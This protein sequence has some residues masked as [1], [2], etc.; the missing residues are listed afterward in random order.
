[1]GG[2]D[3]VAELREIRNASLYRKELFD[4]IIIYIQADLFVKVCH[5]SFSYTEINNMLHYASEKN[6]YPI[7]KETSHIH[8]FINTTY[9]RPFIVYLFSLIFRYVY[10]PFVKPLNIHSIYIKYLS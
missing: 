8:K 4:D 5:S 1:M 2:V 10:M 6:F 9:N 7:K 3:I